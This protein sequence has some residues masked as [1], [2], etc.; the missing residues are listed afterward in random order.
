[1]SRV[2]D[3]TKEEADPC[4]RGTPGCAIDHHEDDGDCEGY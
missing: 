4:L 1:M 2:Y 3:M